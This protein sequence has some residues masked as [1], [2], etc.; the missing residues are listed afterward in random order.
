[1]SE[2]SVRFQYFQHQLNAR[3]DEK[4]RK[5]LIKEGW[6]GVGLFW[7]LLEDLGLEKSHRLECDYETLSFDM[8]APAELIK[9]VV[10]N[11]GLFRVNKGYFTSIKLNEFM[12]AV[13][14]K[15]QRRAEAGKKGGKAKAMLKQTDSNATAMPEQCQPLKEDKI[16]EEEKRE[17]NNTCL[18]PSPD[19]E[20]ENKHDAVASNGDAATTE[21]FNFSEQ[22]SDREYLAIT[23]QYMLKYAAAPTQFTDR[24]IALMAPDKWIARGGTDFLHQKHAAADLFIK[25]EAPD[26]YAHRGNGQCTKQERQMIDTWLGM[27]QEARIFDRE[28]IDKFRGFSHD[29]ANNQVIL[30]VADEPAAHY[31]ENNYV[32]ALAP[33]LRRRYGQKVGLQYNLLAKEE[34]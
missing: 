17:D 5:L 28:V 26:K 32:Q 23:R 22:V 15:Y 11:Y 8:H 7:G 2:P 3:K 25:V 10:E 14:E 33:V 29:E 9:R 13:E 30:T 31:I 24:L 18:S 27:L 12:E 4:L 20:A 34:K 16:R 1:M 6:A 19:V 21:E